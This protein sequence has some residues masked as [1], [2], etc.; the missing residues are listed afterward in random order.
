MTLSNAAQMQGG[1]GGRAY[2]RTFYVLVGSCAIVSRPVHRHIIKAFKARLRKTLTTDA[3]AAPLMET[4][5][6]ATSRLQFELQ[7]TYSLPCARQYLRTSTQNQR[8][9]HSSVSNFILQ[10][11]DTTKYRYPT[12]VGNAVPTPKRT[13]PWRANRHTKVHR[14]TNNAL[15]KIKHTLNTSRFGQI[16]QPQ[17]ASLSKAPPPPDLPLAHLPVEHARKVAPG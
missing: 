13:V 6:S 3:V 10:G 2:Y 16:N 14:R 11:I 4:L 15:N 17:A 7:C 8:P 1:Y 12:P 9:A 5:E